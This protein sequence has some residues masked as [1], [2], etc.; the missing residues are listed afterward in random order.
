MADLSVR[1]QPRSKK[2][3]VVGVRGEQVVIRV[4]APPVDGRANAAL[5]AFIAK[6]A[7]VPKSSVT[8]VRGHTSRD[9]VV[10]VEGV[11]ERRLRRALGVGDAG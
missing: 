6:R 4:N 5:T 11:D 9:K 3:E 7:G 2:D 8:I 10:R 1:L